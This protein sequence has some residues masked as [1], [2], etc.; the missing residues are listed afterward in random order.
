VD[1]SSSIVSVNGGLRTGGLRTGDLMTEEEE[2]IR[3]QVL[4]GFVGRVS[5]RGMS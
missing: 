4:L 5:R 2:D 1:R 3:E